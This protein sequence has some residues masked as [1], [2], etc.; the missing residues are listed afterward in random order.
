MPR[1]R[2]GKRR[3]LALVRLWRER[4]HLTDWKVSVLV[5]PIPPE[6]DC[7]A[8]CQAQPEYREMVVAVDNEAVTPD[9]LEATIVHELLHGHVEHLAGLALAMAG[10]DPVKREVVRL[11]EESLVVTLERAFMEAYATPAPPSLPAA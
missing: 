1:R 9:E 6:E 5:E 7:K 10:D 4:L 2:I 8:Y 3:V 11:A